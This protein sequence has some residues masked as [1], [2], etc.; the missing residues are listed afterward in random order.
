MSDEINSQL[1]F[2][3][4]ERKRDDKADRKKK[5]SLIQPRQIKEIGDYLHP[6]KSV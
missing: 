1:S 2:G 3:D 5:A 4:K 6:V